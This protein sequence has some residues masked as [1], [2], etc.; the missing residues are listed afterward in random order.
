[1]F[2]QRHGESA[3]NL[4]N[5]FTCRRLDPSLTEKGERQMEDVVPYY[6]SHEIGRI[7]TSPS[8]R[9]VESAEILGSRLGISPQVNECLLEVDV[10]D[11]EGESEREPG[12]LRQFFSVVE[13]WLI[14]RKN[15]RFPGG[16]SWGEVEKR[17]KMLDLLMSS[18]PAIFVGHT[19][20]FAVF[21]GTRGVAFDKVE[22][23]FL[24]RA[25]VASFSP[26]ERSW[27]ME[28]NVSRSSRPK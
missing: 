2:L 16:E 8:K 25:G 1:M 20:L 28:M 3:T 7:L 11:L 5:T 22:E 26:S 27:R 12:L 9:A 21:L 18:S 4:T 14:H 6:A 13:D 19:T 23:L 17:L 10:G 24:P 15:T